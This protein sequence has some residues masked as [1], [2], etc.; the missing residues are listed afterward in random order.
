MTKSVY[1]R[2]NQV[3]NVALDGLQVNCRNDYAVIAL[4]SLN[5]KLDLKHTDAMLLTTVGTVENTDMKM[6]LAPD[7][8]Q[9]N[10]GLPPYLQMDDFGK[11]PIICE[12]IEADVE[13]ETERKNMVV[14][15]VNSEGIFVGNVPTK[16]EDGKL[17][18][19]LGPKYPSIYYLIQAE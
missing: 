6:S 3:G 10:D 18:F 13:I 8:I 2:L 9:K 15:A 16:Y 17:K 4:S 12:V 11:A 14:W 19:T 5:N 1:G 7:A